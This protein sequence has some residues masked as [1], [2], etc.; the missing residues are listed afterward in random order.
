MR[1]NPRPHGGA[2]IWIDSTFLNQVVSIHAP[3][4]GRPDRIDTPPELRSFQSTP[5][6]GGDQSV[7]GVKLRFRSFNPRPHG[8]ATGT[9]NPLK[10]MALQFQSTPPRGGDVTVTTATAVPVA[11]QSTPPRGGDLLALETPSRQWPFQSTPPRGGDRA[12]S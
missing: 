11:F 5:P 10:R 7:G 8:G 12:S 9:E 2:T 6:R 3:T 4:G 1:F